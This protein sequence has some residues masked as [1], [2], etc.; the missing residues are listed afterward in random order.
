MRTRLLMLMIAVFPVVACAQMKVAYPEGTVFSSMPPTPASSSSAAPAVLAYELRQAGSIAEVGIL[1]PFTLTKADGFVEK[2]MA[3]GAFP[4][5]RVLCARNGKIFYDKSFG[6]LSYDTA[7]PPVMPGTVY[8]LA[9]LTKIV[10]TTLAVMH[11][12][13]L[14]KIDLDKRLSDYL[15]MTLGTDKAMLPLRALLLH[16]A[17]LKAWIPFYKSFYDSTGKHL[18]DTAFRMKRDKHYNIEVAKDLWLRGDYRDTVW[19]MILASP[20]ENAGK[21]VYSD[22]DYYFLAAVVER[23]IGKP[24][25]EYVTK[26]FY[27]PMGLKTMG[28]L[29]LQHLNPAIIAPTEADSAFRH[30]LLQGYVH[31]PGAALFGGVAG[32]AGV[33]SNAGD[34]AVIFQMLLNEGR[35]RGKAYF[36]PETVRQFT[37][38]GSPISRRG[39]GFDKPTPDPYDA[40]PTSTRCSG[41]TFGHQGFTGTCAWADPATGVVFV[42]LSNRV[43]PSAENG[44]INK[45]S[46]RTV[47]QDALYEALGIAEDTARASVRKTQLADM[48]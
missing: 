44:L 43:Y 40:G 10:S 15:P 21:Y 1:D 47:V 19:K 23:V 48:K 20:L 35:Y 45:M 6:K 36:M 27:A 18:L 32:H 29:P 24:L 41:Y 8:D 16:Q 22:L 9:S 3:A 25:D 38:Y 5:C 14:G 28:Y 26:T 30:Q 7:A 42:F 17:G 33:F 46:T 13:E 2:S 37:G 12:W 11:L 34:V 39:L 31:D 4:G